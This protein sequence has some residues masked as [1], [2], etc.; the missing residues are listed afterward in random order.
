[1]TGG[2]TPN[3]DIGGD[4]GESTEDVEDS[5]SEV[6]IEGLESPFNWIESDELAFWGAF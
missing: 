5:E 6:T 3:G 4:F 2:P 1:M